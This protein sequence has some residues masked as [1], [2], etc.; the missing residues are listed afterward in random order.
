LV[1]PTWKNYRWQ[2]KHQTGFAADDF[3]I[4]W[5][6]QVATCPEGKTS[7]SWTPT[8]DW[9]QNPVMKIRF[10]TRDCQACPS[11]ARC[12]TTSR[13]YHQRAGI[14]GTHSQALRT[15]GLRRSWYLGLAK[16][17]LRHLGTAAALNLLRTTAWLSG[18]SRTSTRIPPLVALLREAA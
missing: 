14:E 4:D 9:L 12:T 13:L 6:A 7:L 3:Q 2:A 17:R 5:Q 10:S 1:E 11:R 8:I 15:M 16:T 18:V